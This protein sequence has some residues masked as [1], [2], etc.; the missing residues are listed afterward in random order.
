VGPAACCNT[1]VAR[2][3]RV[4]GSRG[5]IQWAEQKMGAPP[6]SSMSHSAVMYA[7]AGPAPRAAVGVA[8]TAGGAADVARSTMWSLGGSWAARRAGQSP[9]GR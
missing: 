8:G 2:V 4:A 7:G 9:E 1:L 6:S 5:T 3:A